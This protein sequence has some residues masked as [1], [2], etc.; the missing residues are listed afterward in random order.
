VNNS[1]E[2]IVTFIVLLLAGALIVGLI[3]QRARI[4]YAVAL[5]LASLPFHHSQVRAFGSQIFF[6]FLPALIFEA[7]WNLDIASLRNTWKPIALLAIPGVLFTALLVGYGLSWSGQLPL[8][9]GILLG[10]IIAATDPI[11][12]IAIFRRLA[13]PH[14]LAMIVEGE[15]LFNDGV[16]VVLYSAIVVSLG[17]HE[18]FLPTATVLHAVIA[19]LSGAA[20]GF[21]GAFVIATLLRGTQDVMLHIV[22]SVVA[23]YGAYLAAENL[24]VSGIFS[25]LTAG[26]ALRAF[27]SFPHGEE[28]QL[29]IDRFW[30]VLAFFANS[31][32]FLLLGL[33]IDIQRI[34]HEPYLIISTI[35]LVT[36]ARVVFSY[37]PLR[38]ALTSKRRTHWQHV[39]AI[40][41]MRGALSLALAILLPSTTPY[42]AVIIDAVFGV[43]TTTLIIQG[44]S[45]SPI[46]RRLT[47]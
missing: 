35:L 20:L 24:H 19:A 33:R 3:A 1:L 18:N 12:V 7:A 37:G 2:S 27:D 40:A 11:A 29:E 41:G 15:S 28:T 10:S 45:I 8:R 34:F 17:P 46:L 39:I 25:V 23:A 16:A 21:V 22:A 30:S 36:I 47:L 14:E 32:V 42:R 4:P 13:V 5:L 9:E 38:F 43:V 44:L 6:I 31:L 26:I